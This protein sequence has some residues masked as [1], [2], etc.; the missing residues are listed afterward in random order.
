MK[1]V[2][3]FIFSV[4]SF[5]TCYSQSTSKDYIWAARTS[6][7]KQNYF[8]AVG[9]LSKAIELDPKSGEAYRVRASAKD[10]LNDYLGAKDDYQ[11]AI[12]IDPQ[13]KDAYTDRATMESRHK[14]YRAAIRDCKKAIEIDPKDAG[15]YSEKGFAEGN[16][17]MKDQAC[18]DLSTAGQ[19]GDAGAYI[20]ISE[21]CN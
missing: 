7:Y 21:F 20:M 8:E 19:L 13:D 14:D 4:L 11:Q 16:L 15:A 12:K 17:G 2:L 1:T 5:S 3:L 18:R 9:T 6:I 10:H